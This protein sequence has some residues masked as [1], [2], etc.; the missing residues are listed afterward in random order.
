MHMPRVYEPNKWDK[1]SIHDEHDS[2]FFDNTVRMTVK[3]SELY[4]L[5]CEGH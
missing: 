1:E 3:V 5:D 4:I 2:L